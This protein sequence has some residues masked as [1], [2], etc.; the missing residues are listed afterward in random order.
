[1]ALVNKMVGSSLSPSDEVFMDDLDA[2]KVRIPQP[3]R[4]LDRVDD[5]VLADIA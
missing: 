4:I 5:Q 2:D 3:R 1:L